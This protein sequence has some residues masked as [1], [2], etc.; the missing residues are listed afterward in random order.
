M[1]ICLLPL[2]TAPKAPAENL[3][4]FK[5][6]MRRVAPRRPDLVCLPECTFTGYLYEEDDL[7]RFAE[8]LSGPTMAEMSRIAR[9]Y[10]THLCFGLLERASGKVYDTAVLLDRSGEIVLAQRKISEKPPF[11]TGMRVESVET[12]HGKMAILICGDLFHREA[13]VRLPADLDLLL[14]PMARAF[15][16]R[17]PDEERWLQEERNEYLNAVKA[18]KVTAALVNALETGI[19]EPSFGGAMVVDKHGNL[20]AE[21]PHGTD[22]VLMYDLDA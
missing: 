20:L 21:S 3:S 13:V 17:S 18:A 14:V 8:P 1:R 7:A 9:T 11:A 10:Q 5:Q 22:E 6:V 19:E 16:G 12:G 4:R 2:R 15:D